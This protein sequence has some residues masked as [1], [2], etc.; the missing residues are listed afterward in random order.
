LSAAPAGACR[1]CSLRATGATPHWSIPDPAA[2][3]DG[4]P[5]FQRT[6]TDLADRIRFL[7]FV[8][9]LRP[10]WRIMSIRFEDIVSVRY[11]VNDVQ[12]ALDFYT[13]HSGFTPNTVFLP[14]FV[15]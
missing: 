6:A 12:A 1:P 14:A 9:R 8:S 7:A 3:P 5:A 15:D 4:Y 13:T 10:Q 2:Q 11:M